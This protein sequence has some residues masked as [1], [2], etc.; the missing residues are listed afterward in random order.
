MIRHIVMWKL[1]ENYSSMEK[2]N[3]IKA[4]SSKLLALDG[5]IE[6]LRSISTHTNSSKAPETNYELML[7][8][9]FDSIE[10]LKKYS[11]HPEHLTVVTFAKQFKLQRSCVDYE[12]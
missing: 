3:F 11:T 5:K 6:E 12:Y 9:S 8:T 2:S 4:F 1:D 10:D 7:D